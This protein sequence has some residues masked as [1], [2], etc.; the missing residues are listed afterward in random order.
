MA[1]RQRLESRLAKELYF[2]KLFRKGIEDRGQVAEPW[3]A[4]MCPTERRV[5]WT[6]TRALHHAHWKPPRSVA[7]TPTR[8]PCPMQEVRRLDPNP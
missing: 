8:A 5:A 6:P 2:Q 1:A 3:S 7:W 4:G